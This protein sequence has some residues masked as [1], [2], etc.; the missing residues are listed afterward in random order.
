MRHGLRHG[1]LRRGRVGAITQQRYSAGSAAFRSCASLH[2]LPLNKRAV[3]SSLE[4]FL[5]SNS[6]SYLKP[7][8]FATA[9]L[10]LELTESVLWPLI[11]F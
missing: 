2:E 6:K 8:T 10:P 9:L 7:T 4:R 3:D 11:S 1:F 5:C